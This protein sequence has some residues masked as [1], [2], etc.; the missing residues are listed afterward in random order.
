MFPVCVRSGIIF[1]GVRCKSICGMLFH[2]LIMHAM[3]LQ[4]EINSSS[5]SLSVQHYRAVITCHHTITYI[6]IYPHTAIRFMLLRQ[7]NTTEYL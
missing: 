1:T 2:L 7:E 6:P 3:L 4:C 5:K